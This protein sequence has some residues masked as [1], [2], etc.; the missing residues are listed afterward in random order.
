MN[1]IRTLLATTAA[2][3]AVPLLASA[4]AAAAPDVDQHCVADIV[5]VNR[6][7]IETGPET[8]FATE[9][10]AADHARGGNDARSADRTIGTHYSGTGYSGSSIRITGDACTG[11]TWTPSASWNNNIESSRHHCPGDTTTFYDGS[12]C[13]T[14]SYAITTDRTSLSSMNNRASCVRYG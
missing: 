8:C 7:V 10:E 9:T 6:G 2:A 4:S 1:P 13:S 14:G 12:N 3:L 5:Q 11:G